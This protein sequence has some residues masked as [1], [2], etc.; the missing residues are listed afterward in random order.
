LKEKVIELQNS[1]QDIKKLY[2]GQNKA[3]EE[4]QPLKEKLEDMTNKYER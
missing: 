3:L 1:L 4:Q 2:E